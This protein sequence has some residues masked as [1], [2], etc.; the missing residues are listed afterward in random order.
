M[1][2]LRAS[3]RS[4]QVRP[5]RSPVN[6]KGPPYESAGPRVNLAGGGW[7]PLSARFDM[8][9]AEVL[10][11]S[12]EKEARYPSPLEASAPGYAR[13]APSETKTAPPTGTSVAPLST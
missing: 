9:T 13:V 2:L 3:R 4:L 1:T 10:P 7:V 6:A 11:I 8:Y 12:P 5:K